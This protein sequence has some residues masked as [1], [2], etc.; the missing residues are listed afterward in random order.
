[1]DGD[2]KIDDP[3]IVN[4]GSPWYVERLVAPVNND[5]NLQRDASGNLIEDDD[6][7]G[8]GLS[9]GQ[10]TDSDADGMSNIYE[11]NY[12]IRTGGWKNLFIYNTRY[13]VLIGGGGTG[14][15]QYGKDMNYPAF[16]N[17]LKEMYDKLIGYNYLDENIYSFFWDKTDSYGYWVDGP[18]VWTHTLLV[19]NYFPGKRLIGDAMSGI[20]KKITV[21]DF[22]FFT[23]I[24]HGSGLPPDNGAFDIA[25]VVD[26]GAGPVIT[27]TKCYFGPIGNGLNLKEEINANIK[28]YARAIFVM[29]SCEVSYGIQ[30]L[31][32]DN[33]IVIA[34]EN[35]AVD[36]MR[37]VEDAEG[38]T[39]C[40]TGGVDHWAFI[41]QGN[42]K[43]W[44]TG[45]HPHDGFILS[46]GSISSAN[47]ILHAFNEGYTAASNNR[48]NH[49]TRPRDYTS[50]PMLEDYSG[51]GNTGTQ[52]QLS[53]SSASDEGWLAEHTYL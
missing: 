8:D 46:L 2:E 48:Y 41:Y 50:H 23:E 29:Q 5:K 38:N 12:G 34:P 45:D 43:D 13:A 7:D 6:I 15:N 16:G 3:V 52:G 24:C 37:V 31:A 35:H 53:P 25:T 21:N 36:P 17:D 11:Y 27:S 32:G 10:E 51:N 44:I 19:D 39:W 40:M 49:P 22:F 42:N 18:A 4:P 28:N 20:G 33:R 30:Q 14:K 9:N 47:D 26:L 1:M